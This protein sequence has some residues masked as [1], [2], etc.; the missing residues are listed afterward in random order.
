MT[1]TNAVKGLR[2]IIQLR[3][4]MIENLDIMIKN[5]KDECVN[6]MINSI[7]DFM[8]RDIGSFEGILREIQSKKITKV[9]Y[10]HKKKR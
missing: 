3:E 9:P 1:V 5:G 4:K 6:G 10:N 2:N 8:I 7:K